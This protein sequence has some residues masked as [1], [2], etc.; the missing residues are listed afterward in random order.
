MRRVPIGSQE[1]R[2]LSQVCPSFITVWPKFMLPVKLFRTDKVFLAI[3]PLEKSIVAKIWETFS[4]I[5]THTH[6]TF[7]TGKSICESSSTGK[8]L[9]KT[10]KRT[11]FVEVKGNSGVNVI[12]IRTPSFLVRLL[13]NWKRKINFKCSVVV[14]RQASCWHVLCYYRGQFWEKFFQKPFYLTKCH[15]VL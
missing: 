9:Y 7:F 6:K 5:H 3:S 15:L 2:C 11:T 8:F 4:C 14:T 13:L 1:R 10:N 12:F